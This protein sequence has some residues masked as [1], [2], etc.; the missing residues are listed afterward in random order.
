MGQ[1]EGG[2][3]EFPGGSMERQ[4]VVDV[5][6]PGVVEGLVGGSQELEEA[7]FLYGKRAVLSTLKSWNYQ[8][9]FS[10]SK[11]LDHLLYYTADVDKI[12]NCQNK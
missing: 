12:L 8:M 10:Y 9:F 6:G 7:S 2:G 5:G 1:G 3:V 4:V 11:E